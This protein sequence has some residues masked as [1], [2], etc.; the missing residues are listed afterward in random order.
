MDKSRSTF[1]FDRYTSRPLYGYHEEP[2][3]RIPIVG[4]VDV[5]V[6]GGS[7]SGTAAAIC[8]ARHGAA[9][10]LLERYGF[11]GGQSV[12]SSVVQ[13]EKRAFINNLGAVATRGIAEE[14][15]ERIVAKG[16]SDG[17]WATPPGCEEMRD[18]EEWLDVEAMI[19]T[20]IEMCEEAGVE[21]L[22][23]TVATDVML[24][25]RNPQLPRMTGVIFENKT[26]RFAITANVVIDATADLD[27]VWRA[28]GEEGCGMRDPTERMA[29]G[30]Y[31]W[32]GG[33][34][35]EAFAD[36]LLTSSSMTGYPDPGAY[37]DKL[38]Q[39]LS[40]N[41]L[42][43]VRGFQDILDEAKE[44]GLLSRVQEALS[45]VDARPICRL[46][47]KSIGHGRWCCAF[48][49]LRNLN[50]LDTWE[51][52]NYEILRSKVTSM[53]LPIM[54]L[55]PGWGECYIARTNLHVGGRESRYLK[56]VKV[57]K[58]ENIFSSESE[59]GPTPP[60]TVGRSG[61]H[62]PGKNRLKV[63]YPIPYG[64]IVPE[65]LDGVLCCTRAVGA[66]PPVALN[67]HRGIVP[68][69]VVGQAAGTAAALA[70]RTGVE[71]RDVNLE[72]LQNAL[73]QD[74]VVLDEE[75]VEFDF[76]IPSQG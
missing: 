32:F 68:T 50:L 28:I 75:R 36:Y 49:A 46:G 42:V 59:S 66:A 70:V 17:L 15:V 35:N 62:D 33:I 22:F 31:V 8:A 3:R 72:E 18:G 40:E 39:H 37:P 76:E 21:I 10:S 20:L 67:A 64:M 24:D 69:I 4:D 34:S 29:G 65:K 6:V 57:L 13:W 1:N 9:V 56:A 12:Y 47:M 60:D 55:I 11:L 54:R 48:T 58:E 44:L 61:A 25:R 23:H 63:A 41:K 73:R 43:Y 27:L 16:G 52:S 51:V 5:L 71:P 53:M 26:G 30:F 7:P 14:M 45:E 74:N 19:L 2:T 38:V